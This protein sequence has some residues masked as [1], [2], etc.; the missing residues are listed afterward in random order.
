MVKRV[1][2]LRHAQ[3]RRVRPDPHKQFVTKDTRRRAG[4]AGQTKLFA[5]NSG[6]HY[7]V[8]L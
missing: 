3:A 7:I 2:K 8:F 1:D 4:H 6:V 5:G